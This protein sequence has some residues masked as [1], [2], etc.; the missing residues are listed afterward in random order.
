MTSSRLKGT[1]GFLAPAVALCLGALL[2][3]APAQAAKTSVVT[4]LT[5]TATVVRA[6]PY[7]EW[8]ATWVEYAHEEFALY[9]INA[10][11]GEAI[12][13]TK[14]RHPGGMCWIP[15]QSPP[16]LF[17]CKADRI[18][19]LDISRVLYYVYDPI[20]REST[21][22]GEARD[23]LETYKLDPI[24]A[25]DGSVVFHYTLDQGV[26]EAGE[27]SVPM[28]IRYE[29]GDREFYTAAANANIAGDYDLSS[30]GSMLYWPLTKED[31]GDL[32]FVGW[33]L[34]AHDEVWNSMYYADMNPADGGLFIKVDA[35]NERIAM[36]ASSS[37][38]PRLQMCLY[39]WHGRELLPPVPVFLEAGEEI[40]HYDWK[41]LTGKVYTVIHNENTGMFSIELLDP[42]TGLRDVY[43]RGT[44]QISFVDYA[45]GSNTYYYAVVNNQGS[46]PQTYVIRALP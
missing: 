27:G 9:A 28:F 6:T 24:A 30:D 23:Q 40:L 12:E 14:T 38:Q 22:I 4:K 33:N 26:T 25:E 2:I 10:G 31:T 29:A 39:G 41:G 11:S 7:D 35:A 17:Y 42:L 37:G 32:Y 3:G 8:L 46:A 1:S 44:D 5:G 36:L 45:P 34:V 18:P 19:E 43:V 21:K 13:V 20:A 16:Q 15:R